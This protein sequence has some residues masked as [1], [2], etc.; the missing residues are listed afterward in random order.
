MLRIFLPLPLPAIAVTRIVILV[1][2]WNEF[3][4]A[5]AMLRDPAR[6]TPPLKVFNLVAGRYRV[7]WN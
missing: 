4:A 1:G 7:E 6:L 3:V 2:S 5:L